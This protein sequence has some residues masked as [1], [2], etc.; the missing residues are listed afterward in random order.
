[1]T[2]LAGQKVR[3]SQLQALEDSVTDLSAQ[4]DGW[5]YRLTT[6]SGSTGSVVGVLRLDNLNLAA[7]RVY[8]LR[9]RCHPDG[10]GDQV[11]TE[12]RFNTAGAA[13]T[14]DTL[15]VGSQAY[16]TVAG[17]REFAVIFAVA[18]SGSYSFLLCQTRTSGANTST[19]FCDTNRITE[20][21]VEAMGSA[22]NTGVAV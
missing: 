22:S 8:E 7:S 15:V 3:A 11:R 1:L 4:L 20:M 18:I 16:D 12:I 13:G 2:F 14:G 6:S 19:L 21:T 5:G 17:H 9:Y 10:T